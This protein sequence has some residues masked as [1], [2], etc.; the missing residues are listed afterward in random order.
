MRVGCHYLEAEQELAQRLRYFR[1]LR[2]LEIPYMVLPP[3]DIW[4]NSGE[5]YSTQRLLSSI[6]CELECLLSSGSETHVIN[7]QPEDADFRPEP[8]RSTVIEAVFSAV[9]ADSLALSPIDIDYHRNNQN[10]F[11][12]DSN[13]LDRKCDNQGVRLEHASRF[14]NS[15]SEEMRNQSHSKQTLS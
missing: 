12:F 14:D 7:A 5:M 11:E 2:F 15:M 10:G 13:R 9:K 4:F 1:K 6:Q 3:A 8:N